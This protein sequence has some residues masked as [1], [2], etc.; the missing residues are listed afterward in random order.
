MA[1]TVY[2]FDYHSLL[3]GLHVGLLCWSQHTHMTHRF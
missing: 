3:I 2:Y 1:D